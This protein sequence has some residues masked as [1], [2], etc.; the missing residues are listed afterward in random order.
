M[1]PFPAAVWELQKGQMLAEIQEGT[2][3]IKFLSIVQMD[4]GFFYAFKVNGASQP[5]LPDVVATS[6]LE[7]DGGLIQKTLPVQVES[8]GYLGAWNVGIMHVQ[9][10][11]RPEQVITL[12]IT[13]AGNASPVWSLQPLKQNYQPQETR[14]LYISAPESDEPGCA[15]IEF[16]GPVLKYRIA[17]LRL[18]QNGQ[19]V[20]EV[21][22]IFFRIPRT[23]EGVQAIL[24]SQ[25]EY[26][27][28]TGSAVNPMTFHTEGRVRLEE[29][30]PVSIV[31]P[32][33]FGA[34]RIPAPRFEHIEG[35][36]WPF[37]NG[38]G[39]GGDMA[40]WH[41][42]LKADVEISE[43]ANHYAAQLI[44]ANWSRIEQQHSNEFAWQTWTFLDENDAIW[45]GLFFILKNP[46]IERQ[47][48]FYA[49]ADRVTEGY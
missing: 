1:S 43:L 47:Y 28:F 27:A 38:G 21:A 36:E 10:I 2:F 6:V 33:R 40:Y 24:L 46:E 20:K 34:S 35:L 49:R 29:A 45:K 25:E 44:E 11:D 30:Q 48:V 17:F 7:V 31:H 5:V 15:E 14:N 9:W 8:L 16:Y 41:G 37:G 4:M 22:P 26:L 18:R 42:V 13:Q 23:H 3:C 39:G 12:T 19:P 32:R